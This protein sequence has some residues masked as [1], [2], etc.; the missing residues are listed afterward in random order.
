MKLVLMFAAVL[1]VGLLLDAPQSANGQ[2]QAQNSVGCAPAADLHYV[3]GLTNV[4]D[5]LPIEGGRWLVGGSLK[6]GS[7][8]LYLIDTA[9]KTGRPVTLTIA[10]DPDPS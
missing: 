10:S 5:F 7:V 1:A 8:G 9:A 3:C 2:S 4:E 6:V